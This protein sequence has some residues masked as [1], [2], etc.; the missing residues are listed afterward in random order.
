MAGRTLLDE[1]QA[2]RLG[3]WLL[4]IAALSVAGG[5]I[6]L[7]YGLGFLKSDYNKE[8]ADDVVLY[9][10]AAAGMLALLRAGRL[11]KLT[12]AGGTYEFESTVVDKINKDSAE[13]KRL[14]AELAELRN[15]RPNPSL[16]DV[17]TEK[18]NA[19]P[20]SLIKPQSVKNDKQKNRF[21]GK[22]EAGGYKL[23]VVFHSRSN[24][25]VVNVDLIVTR[26]DG[27]PLTQNVRFYLHQT[28]RPQQILVAPE[29]GQAVLDILCEGGFTVGAWVVDTDVLLELDLA[30]VSNAPRV[31]QER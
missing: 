18:A 13:V 21:G 25:S 9:L 16:A 24:A 5:A 19:W 29:D 11:T 22:A 1:Q 26:S 14:A 2:N 28:F 15:P 30:M 17:E 12:F 27:S 6:H 3:G 7:V 8:V 31:I 20:G 23:D 4:A 10:A